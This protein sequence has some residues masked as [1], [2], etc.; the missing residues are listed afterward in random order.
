MIILYVA[1][2]MMVITFMTVI[3]CMMMAL[4]IMEE[5]R[6]QPTP[7][8]QNYIVIFMVVIMINMLMILKRAKHSSCILFVYDDGHDGRDLYDD[9]HDS[10]KV[11]RAV[12][13]PWHVNLL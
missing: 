4:V 12:V 11:V 6:G 7:L 2:W 10:G 13:R 8:V 3:L 5:Q 1:V 9:G